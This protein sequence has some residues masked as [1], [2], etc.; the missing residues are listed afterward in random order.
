MATASMPQS[1]ANYQGLWRAAQLLGLALTVLLL[2]GLFVRPELTLD[3]L[4]N[5]VVPILPATFLVSPAIWRNVC[6]LATLTLLPGKRFGRG[7]LKEPAVR[8]SLVVG[9]ALLLVLVPA[10]RFLFNTNGIV[11]AVTIAGVAL[12]ALGAG[13]AFKRKAGFCNSI[14][15]V[16]P[17]ERLYGQWPLARVPNVRCVPCIGCTER[18]C[19]DLS[20]RESLQTAV[21]SSWG[22]ERWLLSPFGLFAAAFPGFIV[23][24]YQL[25]NGPLSR[26]PGVYLQIATAMVVS[27]LLVALV[28]R[29]L[30]VPADRGLAVLAALAVGLYYWYA[31][32]VI[33]D[34]WGASAVFTWTVRVA[35]LGLVVYWLRRPEVWRSPL[36]A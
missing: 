16:L 6:P 23:G 27:A 14:C 20:T 26:A 8:T 10:R 5:A 24:Y 22:S 1:A 31:A 2:G 32:R 18:G 33:A 15:P 3:L 19:L 34:A 7:V 25:S 12:L 35:A 17:V 11:L 30:R 28:V 29:V 21:G 13:F 4:W 9:V 36:R